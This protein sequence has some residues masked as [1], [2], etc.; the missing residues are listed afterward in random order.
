MC[1]YSIY[2]TDDVFSVANLRVVQIRETFEVAQ[3]PRGEGQGGGVALP[4][5][6][7]FLKI[8]KERTHSGQT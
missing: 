8:N 5:Q 4:G 2:T 7:L 1:Q 3:R 6:E